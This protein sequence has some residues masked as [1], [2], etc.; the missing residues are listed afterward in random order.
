IGKLSFYMTPGASLFTRELGI[1]LFLACVGLLSGA[2]FV[3]TI[4]NGGWQW[5]LYGVA[6]TL[7]PVLI[8]GII[9]RLM[10]V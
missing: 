4:L 2:K 1:I 5:M 6:I 9:A 7:I 10:K 3:E 8:V